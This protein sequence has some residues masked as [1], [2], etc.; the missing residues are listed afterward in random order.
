MGLAVLIFSFS[1][2]TSGD[3]TNPEHVFLPFPLNDDRFS[4]LHSPFLINNN[5]TTTL[6]LQMISTLLPYEQYYSQQYQSEAASRQNHH[7]AITT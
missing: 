5:L 1:L 3:R 2:Q 6:I 4:S 7:V